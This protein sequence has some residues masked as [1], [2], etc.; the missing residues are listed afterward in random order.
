MRRFGAE[1]TR[2]GRGQLRSPTHL[3]RLVTN[4]LDNAR[5]YARH[6]IQIQ[7]R[8]HDATAELTVTD[9]GPGIPV[10]D[11]EHVFERFARLDTARCRHH[12]GTGLGL[13]IARDIA[14]A[15]NGTL[16]VEDAPGGGARFVLRLPSPGT[17]PTTRN[18]HDLS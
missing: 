7:V 12:G 11:H 17:P 4:L 2:A 9:D 16:H 10:Q 1:R 14:H 8:H 18:V 5:T 3:G 13:A 15:H 6:S